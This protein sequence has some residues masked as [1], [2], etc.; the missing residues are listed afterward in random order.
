MA[1][2]FFFFF[3]EAAEMKGCS[4]VVTFPSLEVPRP[5]TRDFWG[6]LLGVISRS[7]FYLCCNIATQFWTGYSSY[8]G[9]GRLC[10]EM[11]PVQ[12]LYEEHYKNITRLQD[13]VTVQ[14][15]TMPWC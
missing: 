5:E 2:A 14:V 10:K 12:H 13:R 6:L 8:P 1:I 7:V 4:T 15:G 9:R 3:V 11:T